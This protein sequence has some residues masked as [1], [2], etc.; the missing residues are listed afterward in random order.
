[1]SKRKFRIDDLVTLDKYSSRDVYFSID[2]S[3][4]FYVIKCIAKCHSKVCIYRD[5]CCGYITVTRLS[6]QESGCVFCAYYW[7]VINSG[8]V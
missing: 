4:E 1:M 5:S 7:K 6:T 8:N 2:G 3:N